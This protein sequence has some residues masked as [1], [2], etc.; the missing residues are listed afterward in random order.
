LKTRGVLPILPTVLLAER[1][2][3][4]CRL[5]G[6]LL[7]EAGYCVLKAGTRQEVFEHLRSARRIDIVVADTGLRGMPGWDIAQE[8]HWRRPGVPVVRLIESAADALPVYGMDLSSTVLLQKPFTILELRAVMDRLLSHAVE[9]GNGSPPL[10]SRP[11][12]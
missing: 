12:Y 3:S 9:Q 6:E 11:W 4:V 10:H 5:L 2:A 1:D 8:T 7:G